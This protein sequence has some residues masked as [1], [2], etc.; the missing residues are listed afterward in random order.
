MTR[1][2]ATRPAAPSCAQ[3]GFVPGLILPHPD[4]PQWEL[5]P[6]DWSPRGLEE[7]AHDNG[8]APGA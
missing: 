3:E 7:L 1:A 4:L 5:E 2:P 6:G 8:F